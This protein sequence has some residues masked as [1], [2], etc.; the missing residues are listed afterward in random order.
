MKI[1]YTT[2]QQQQQ[3]Q[4][5]NANNAI[6]ITTTKIIEMNINNSMVNSKHGG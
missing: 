3:Q 5:Q 2:Q 6:P 4:Q 1:R